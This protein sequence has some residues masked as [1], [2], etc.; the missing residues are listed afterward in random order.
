MSEIIRLLALLKPYA[1]WMLLGILV[2]LLSVLANI[3]LMAVSGW[4]IASMAIAG[5]AGVSMNYFSPAA[6]IRA[7]AIA[8]TGGKYAERLVTH[9][10]TFRLLSLLRIWFYQHFEALVP[11]IIEK[12]RSTDL[13]SR[14]QADIDSLNDFYVRLLVPLVVAV[15]TIIIVTFVISLYSVTAGYVMLSMLIIAGI[16]FPIFIAFLGKRPGSELVM[17]KTAL[18][19]AVT[20]GVQG[21]PELIVSGA[22]SDQQKLIQNSSLSLTA[23]QK[24]LSMLT[25]LSNAG[26]MFFA[27]FTMW[28]ITL[29]AVSMLNAGEIKPAELAMLALLALAA[30]EAVMPLPDAF[31]LLGQIQ[32]A[33]KRLF[34]LIDQKPPVEEPAIPAGSPDTFDWKFEAVDFRYDGFSELVL[35]DISLDILAGKKI[36][37]VGPTGAGKSSL[38][39][40][41]LKNRLPTQGQLTLSGKALTEYSAT[42][43]NQWISVVPQQPYL[44]NT[45]LLDNLRLAKPDASDAE[46]R[47]VLKLTQLNDY[48]SSQHDGLNTWVGETGVKLSGGQAKRLAIARALLKAHK[49]LLMDEPSE[50]LD[51][52]TFRQ[53]FDNIVANLEH[54]SLVVITHQTAGFETFDEI[55]FVEKGRIIERGTYQKLMAQKSRFYQFVTNRF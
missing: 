43:I 23:V 29:I 2:S 34:E 4:F 14:I 7:S 31:R 51:A 19:T 53:V 1:G 22:V 32:T 12:Y 52:K 27:G 6:I 44:F 13:F 50:G 41:L 11:G 49:L 5:L 45:S 26:M 37:I 15:L 40:L 38:I 8:R 18:R 28:L 42:D 17:Q 24:V 9:E 55:V 39:Q 48:V 54:R 10:A 35:E 30:F 20:D 16:L 33:A 47:S 3:T 25:G 21:L 46:I 36:A